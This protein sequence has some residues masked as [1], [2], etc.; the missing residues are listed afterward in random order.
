MKV[1]LAIL[2]RYPFIFLSCHLYRSENS[3]IL[4]A[5]QQMS[6]VV[7]VTF[8]SATMQDTLHDNCRQ[9]HELKKDPMLVYSPSDLFDFVATTGNVSGEGGEERTAMEDEDGERGT[10]GEET[11]DSVIS[12][13]LTV[14]HVQLLLS[15]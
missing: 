6:Q 3:L 8:N 14:T 13:P 5:S 11:Q 9:R 10:V 2:Q 1:L 12:H 7:N 4:L 15:Q